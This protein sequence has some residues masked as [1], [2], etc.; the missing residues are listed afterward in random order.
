MDGW[1]GLHEG[2]MRG[3]IMGVDA[4]SLGAL[5]SGTRFLRL[6]AGLDSRKYLDWDGDNGTIGDVKYWGCSERWLQSIRLQFFRCL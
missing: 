2:I 3:H 6:V 1:E 4:G 5:R